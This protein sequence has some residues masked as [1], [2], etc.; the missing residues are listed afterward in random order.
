MKRQIILGLAL[1]VIAATNVFAADGAE[2]LKQFQT[3]E[4]GSQ[5]V[6]HHQLASDGSDHLKAFQT[7]QVVDLKNANV[8]AEVRSEFG[9]QYQRY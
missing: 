4:G 2:H 8:L 3:A 6:S 9:S 5:H 7:A 1:S